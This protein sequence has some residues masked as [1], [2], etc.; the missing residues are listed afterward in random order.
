MKLA[1][2]VV[3]SAVPFTVVKA[4]A[5][6]PLGERLQRKMKESKK[7]SLSNSTEFK[8]LAQRARNKRYMLMLLIHNHK[9]GFTL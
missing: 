7:I 8:A 9:F 6:S 5:N 4:I 1:G 3:F 2:V